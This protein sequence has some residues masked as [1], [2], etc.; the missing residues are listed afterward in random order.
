MNNENQTYQKNGNSNKIYFL[1]AVIVVLIGTNVYLYFKNQKSNEQVVLVNDEKTKMQT[2]IDRIE[3]QLDS[4]NNATVKISDQ[5]KEQQEQAHAKIGELREA[6]RKGKLTQNQLANAQREIKK[7]RDF[8]AQYTAQIEEL[9]SQN[10]TLTTERNTLK[11][12]VDSVS[13]R[14][15]SLQKQNDDLSNKV[16]MAAAL[17]S[18]NVDV[19]AFKV[20]KNGK[21]SQVTKAKT[22]SKLRI[23]F[24]VVANA[25]A[26]TGMHDVF[27]RVMD[28]SGNMI[29]GD[30]APFTADN[31]PMQ[32]TYKT[33][34]DFVNESKAYSVDWVNANPF[35]K[36]TYEVILY[37]DGY[38][39]GKGTVTLQ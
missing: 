19:I 31:M 25:L 18:G 8:V 36:G 39:M 24:T 32:S 27:V 22:A 28:P 38:T 29:T 5:M 4:A 12:Q 11:G 14:A 23:N 2:E 34:I 21:E 20:R 33:S 9:K 26:L 7:L 10:A 1:A 13:Q 6:L 16:T 35:Q 3:V 17:K 30:N 37:A 15:G